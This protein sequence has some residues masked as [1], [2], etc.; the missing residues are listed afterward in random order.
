MSGSGHESCADADAPQ[1]G[2]LVPLNRARLSSPKFHVFRGRAT[3]TA[4]LSRHLL[5][6]EIVELID[7]GAEWA[8][9]HATGNREHVKRF[10]RFLDSFS[11]SQ[12]LD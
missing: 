11:T 1:R 6:L 10:T 12:D 7:T 9:M 8:R 2:N 5:S 4:S 3:G